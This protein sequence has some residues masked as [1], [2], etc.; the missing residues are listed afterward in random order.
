[1]SIGYRIEYTVQW[2]DDT[3][4][5]FQDIGFGS[6]GEWPDIDTCASMINSDITRF[7]WETGPG[8]PDPRMVKEGKA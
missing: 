3:M 8:M 7:E 1:M 2:I 4:P 6:S 5:D